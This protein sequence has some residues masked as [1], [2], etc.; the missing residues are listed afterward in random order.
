[1]KAILAPECQD[2][3]F[4]IF[5]DDVIGENVLGL[6][7]SAKA[8]LSKCKVCGKTKAIRFLEF[9]TLKVWMKN[10]GISMRALHNT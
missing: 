9:H 4:Y 2:N 7:V 1:M 3:D 8:E 10:G 6:P 5:Q